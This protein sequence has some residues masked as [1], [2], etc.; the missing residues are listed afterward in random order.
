M[1]A[2]VFALS[3][4]GL[5]SRTAAQASDINRALQGLPYGFFGH[6]PPSTQ[7]PLN[8]RPRAEW[9]VQFHTR[10]PERRL[11]LRCDTYSRTRLARFCACPDNLYSFRAIMPSG[12]PTH[13]FPPTSARH[14]LTWYLHKRRP[15]LMPP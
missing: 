14:S 3:Y 11:R 2:C 1:C 9:Q 12:P 8:P 10:N 13:V 7:W 6:S 15:R 4:S 5:V